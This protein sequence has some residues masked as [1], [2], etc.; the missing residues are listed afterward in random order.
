MCTLNT[1]VGGS[2]WLWGLGLESLQTQADASPYVNYNR[3]GGIWATFFEML[4]A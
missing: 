4:E 3:G 2:V 1:T